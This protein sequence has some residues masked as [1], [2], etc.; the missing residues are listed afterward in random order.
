MN[1]EELLLKTR[2]CRRFYEDYAIG[3]KILRGLV[4]LAR[5]SASGANLQPL[6]YLL[7]NQPQK[8]ALIFPQLGWA[9][10]L[11]DWPGPSAGERP[12]AYIIVLGDQ[13]ITKN[14]GCDHGIASQSILLGATGLGLAGCIIA[15]VKRDPLRQELSIPDH[16]EILHVIALGK[17]KEKIVIDP[18]GPDGDIKYWRDKDTVHHV[19]K[20]ALDEIIL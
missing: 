13:T 2:S 6:K 20:R 15:A 4:N 19:P 5:L 10:Y 7:C 9:G 11:K 18:L 8:N 1:M 16:L 12:S 17:P 14:F 3:M